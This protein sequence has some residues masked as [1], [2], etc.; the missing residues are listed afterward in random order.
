MELFFASFLLLEI[1]VRMYIEG[2]RASRVGPSMMMMMFFFGGLKTLPV[3]IYIYR[4]SMNL[5]KWVFPK[6]GVGPPN[7]PF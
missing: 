3:G 2:P 4:C 7:H 6:I 1:L 5:S